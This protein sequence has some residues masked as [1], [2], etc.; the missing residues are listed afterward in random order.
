MTKLAL[1][2]LAAAASTAHAFN[3]SLAKEL[4]VGEVTTAKRAAA[5]LVT[6]GK[7]AVGG[8]GLKNFTTTTAYVEPGPCTPLAPITGSVQA[9]LKDGK[10]ATLS[11]FLTLPSACA[12]GRGRGAPWPVVMF[13]SGWSVSKFGPN[14]GRGGAETRACVASRA[15]PSSTHVTAPLFAAY[16]SPPSRTRPTPTT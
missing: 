14:G 15:H 5:S 11:L 13:Y 8:Q 10:N 1:L 9:A 7:P 12:A 6:S 3:A 2:L 16:S 4:A